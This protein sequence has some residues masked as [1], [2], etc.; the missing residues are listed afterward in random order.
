MGGIFSFYNYIIIIIE[1]KSKWSKIF[2]FFL[3]DS[4]QNERNNKK[5]ETKRIFVLFQTQRLLSERKKERNEI[6]KQIESREQ[7]TLNK[8]TIKLYSWN[9]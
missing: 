6:E 8:Q 3:N 1:M 2:I 7:N 9:I 5:N 4:N